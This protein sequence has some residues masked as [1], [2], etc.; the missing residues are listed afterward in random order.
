MNYHED[1]PYLLI[2]Q[3]AIIFSRIAFIHAILELINECEEDDQQPKIYK[4]NF[5]L[6]A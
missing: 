3:P 6:C 4:L 5:P 1:K 2:L